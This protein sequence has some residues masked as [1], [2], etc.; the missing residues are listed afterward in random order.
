MSH[1]A[2]NAMRPS[3]SV[4]LTTYNRANILPH[5][6]EAILCQTLR[7]FELIICDDCSSDETQ[8]VCR[9][10]ETRDGRIRYVRQPE[11]LRMPS[12]LNV[13]IRMA[14]AEYIA[15]LHD[16]DIYRKDLLEK[17]Y[18]TLSKYPNAAFV[19]N[20]Y[21]W[22]DAAGNVL[23]HYRESL[24]EVTD[25]REFLRT[26]S[27]RHASFGSPVWGSVMGR[28]S[29]YENVGPLD[30]RFGIFADVDMWMKLACRYDVAYV[31]E[32]LVALESRDVLP[33]AMDFSY[34][35]AM[36]VIEE[37]F[38]KNRIRMYANAP[39]RLS[40]E[41]CRHRVFRALKGMHQAAVRLKR[42]ELRGSLRCLA[43]CVGYYGS[44]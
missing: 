21:H 2:V 4:V 7:D 17:W 30:E 22:L 14:R 31:R 6:L 12:N 37:I 34:I 15:N 35:G 36:R 42:G 33:S 20:E 41:L 29:C 16:G 1:E 27:F 38:R 9:D 32:P 11:N 13:G 18:G 39:V 3:V 19:F 8:A 24:S 5:T 26:I 25:G 43:T 44:D 28:R 10:F 40:L 23:R